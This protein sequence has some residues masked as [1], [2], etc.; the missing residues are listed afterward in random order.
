MKPTQISCA[1]GNVNDIPEWTEVQGDVR[2]T[3]FYTIYQC[4]EKLQEYVWDLNNKGE[5]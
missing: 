5:F 4:R 3:P 1:A 2:L